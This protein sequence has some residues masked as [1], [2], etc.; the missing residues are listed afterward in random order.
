MER[1]YDDCYKYWGFTEITKE[2][3]KRRKW[4]K[5]TRQ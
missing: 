3:I 1:M 2:G 5:V 4:N